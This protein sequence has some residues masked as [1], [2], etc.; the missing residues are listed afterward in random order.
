[1]PGANWRLFLLFAPIVIVTSL[2]IIGFLRTKKVN[3]VDHLDNSSWL[4]IM[5]LIAAILSIGSFLAF[6]FL[7]DIVG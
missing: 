3:R 2:G 7:Q 5:L 1:M 4:L 6:I